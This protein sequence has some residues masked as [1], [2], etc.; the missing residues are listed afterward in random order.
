MIFGD[1]QTVESAAFERL[2]D[3]VA[4]LKKAIIPQTLQ[5]VEGSR[6]AF[7]F[8]IRGERFV[9][10][11]TTEYPMTPP[12][13]LCEGTPVALAILDESA[14]NG[15]SREYTLEA[16]YHSL[17][18]S[19]QKNEGEDDGN[20]DLA[21]DFRRATSS[22]AFNGVS[23]S[24][25]EMGARAYQEDRSFA[26]DV[27][28]LESGPTIGMWC[29]LD[30]HGGAACAEFGADGLADAVLARVRMGDGWKSALT[31]GFLEID[32]EFASTGDQSGATCALA[33][34]DGLDR[35][36]V[37]HCGDARIVLCRE[38]RAEPLTLDHKAD[39]PK[40]IARITCEGGFIS[41]GRVLGSIAVARA[42]GDRHM[43]FITAR[44]E[45][46]CVD[47]TEHDEFAVIASDGLWDVMSDSNAVDFVRG[48]IERGNPVGEICASLVREAVHERN[49]RD[50]TTAVVVRFFKRKLV[51][52][53]AAPAAAIDQP[54]VAGNTSSSNDA[55]DDSLDD[56]KL[57]DFLLDDGNF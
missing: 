53:K 19:I 5:P 38:G 23:A 37:S 46:K 27:L 6:F 3:D 21:D 39:S 17:L 30:G 36:W 25:T 10:E 12:R 18:Q 34:L 29:V 42:L 8:Q 2:S 45:V 26:H 22:F 35:L 50:N 7:E 14:D 44:P 11:L 56:D 32:R 15:W 41:R 9:L 1:P 20:D 24:H 43:K 28:A 16:V 52:T 49:S 55:L 47:L 57:M 54:F 33:V 40:E 51:A 31:T 13:V 4:A 48:R